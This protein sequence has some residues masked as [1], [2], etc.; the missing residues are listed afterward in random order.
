MRSG[1]RRRVDRGVPWIAAVTVTAG[2]LLAARPR[3]QESAPVPRY[4]VGSD[5]GVVVVDGADRRVIPDSADVELFAWD[6]DGRSIVAAVGT[7]LVRIAVADG[8]RATLVDGLPRVRFPDVDLAT[9][10]IAYSVGTEDPGRGWEVWICEADGSGARPLAHGYGPSFAADGTVWFEDYP[11][12]GA[13]LFQIDPDRA[14]APEAAFTGDVSRYTV[15]CSEDGRHVA[16]SEQGRLLLRGPDGR[17]RSPPRPD[18]GAYDRFPSFSPDGRRVLF[19]RALDGDESIVDLDLESWS[20]RRLEDLTP[21][22]LAS[23]APPPP[24]TRADLLAIARENATRPLER[25]AGLDPD[26]D[27]PRALWIERATAAGLEDD[28]ARGPGAWFL[29]GVRHLLPDEASAAAT[30]GPGDLFVPDLPRVDLAVARALGEWKGSGLWLDGLRSLDVEALEALLANPRRLLSLGGLTALNAPLATRLARIDGAVRLNGLRALGPEVATV[31]ADWRG[32]GERY[33]LSLDGLED[34]DPAVLRAL[35]AT[36]GWGLSLG[37]I[38]SLDE[39]TL[40]ALAR[41][42]GA[43]LDLDGV[44]SLTTEQVDALLRFDAKFVELRAVEEIAPTDR[45]RLEASEL[46]LFHLGAATRGS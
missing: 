13:R 42:G 35:C 41:F 30:L 5:A 38:R 45:R 19:F 28:D 33:V 36:R 24:R 23:Y 15:A 8:A 31:L 46:P 7:A 40:G 10:R 22:H 43:L 17:V 6:R 2:V 26:L 12:D 1:T 39:A 11:A 18:E 9:G 4:A 3:A 14:G 27:F 37:G 16:W 44:A 21:G 25:R 34:P 32:N 20:T 29:N